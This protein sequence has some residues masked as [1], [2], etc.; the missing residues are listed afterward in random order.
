MATD[1]GRGTERRQLKKVDTVRD[2]AT[3]TQNNTT[4]TKLGKFRRA[5]GSIFKKLWQTIARI[6]KP[7]SFLLWPF[8]LKPVVF[9]GR[10]LAKVLL[11]Q[12]FIGAWKEVR[13][14]KWP[15]IK[16]TIRLTIAVFVFSI[17][18]GVLVT[19][20]D[21]GLDKIFRKVFVD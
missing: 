19:V 15:N 9:V 11:L 12:Y 20:T 6:L 13:Q 7:F 18:F 14:V 10:T 16:T 1:K 8:K 2:R 21:Y 5:L 4:T 17:L 3:R